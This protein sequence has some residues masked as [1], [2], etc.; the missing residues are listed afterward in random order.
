[1]LRADKLKAI[2]LLK[3]IVKRDSEHLDA[4]MQLGSILRDKE[5]ERALKIQKHNN[6]KFD[7]RN[8]SV[9]L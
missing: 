8:N 1:M 4:Y 7:K 9:S 2:S 5:P 3:D 6:Y